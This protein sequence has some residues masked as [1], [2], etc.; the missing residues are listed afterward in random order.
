M[1]VFW[2]QYLVAFMVACHGLVYLVFGAVS[3][4]GAGFPQVFQ[5]WKGTSALLGGTFAGSSLRLLTEYLWL[6]AGIGLLA[7]GIAIGL[8]SSLPRVW[9]PL[10]IGA[11]IIG[12]ASFLI[13][14]DGQ[15]PQFANEGGIGMVISLAVISG[16][17]LFPSAFG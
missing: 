13:F 15:V 14:W 4:S 1:A 10:A 7:A 16:A 3:F 9:P 5:P 12:M 8:A 2:L 6:I 11:G 17:A